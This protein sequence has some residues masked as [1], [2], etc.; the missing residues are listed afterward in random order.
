MSEKRKVII[1][2]GGHNGL[3]TAFYLA[4][5][6]LKPLVLETRPIV[7]GCATTEEIAPGFRGPG[8]LARDLFEFSRLLDLFALVNLPLHVSMVLPSAEDHDELAADAAQVEPSGWP[9]RPDETLQRELASRWVSLAAAKPYV[10][11]VTWLQTT[12]A[13]PHL[14]AHGGLF[15]PD[16]TPKPVLDWFK[17]FRARY[18]G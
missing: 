18:L 13:L 16:G 6:G 12:D 14:Y 9:R 4:K 7:G 3:V 17:T 15:R 2:G 5:A 8:S 1:V 10:R 11:S